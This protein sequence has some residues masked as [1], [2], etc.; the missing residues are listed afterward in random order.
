MKTRT[1][2]TAHSGCE[3]TP[4]N[5]R[6]F[7]EAAFAA[8]CDML[9]I[10]L[11]RAGDLLYLSHDRADPADC[12]SFEDFLDL[13]APHPDIRVN[14]DMKEAGC[15]GMVMR[16]ANR[17]GMARQIVFT[18]SAHAEEEEIR[19]A[20]GEFWYGIW[21][22]ADFETAVASCLKTG[23]KIINLE[24]KIVTPETKARLDGLGLGFSCW[25]IDKEP[26]MRRLLSLGIH[27]ITTRRPCLAMRIREEIQG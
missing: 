7:L 24:S 5:S 21:D 4:P 25:T 23:A 19:A 9:E 2:I 17:R 11:N 20:G 18:G 15:C 8:G 14:C 26:E 16:A 13:L 22:P 27:N 3:N 10:D 12:L 1:L 6:A